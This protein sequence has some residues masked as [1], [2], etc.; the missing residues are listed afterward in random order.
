MTSTA[1]P[2]TP[3]AQRRLRRSTTDRIA[4]GVAG[5]L[6]EYFGLDPI[7]FRI[8][9]A[10]SAFF[11]GAGVI[12]Y[13]VAWAAIPSS[14]AEAARLDEWMSQLR[15]HRRAPWIALLIGAVVLWAVGFSWWA[16]RPFLPL[17]AI[18]VIGI[19]LLSRVERRGGSGP[20]PA[21]APHVPSPPPTAS[22]GTE[23]MPFA[24]TAV[25]AQPI[26][27]DAAAEAGVARQNRRRQVG[28]VRSITLAV[29]IATLTVLAICDA[30]AGIRLPV[31][32]WVTGGIVLIGMLVGAV[33]RRTPWSLTPLLIFA[34]IG[35][36]AFGNTGASLHD[37][38]GQ[39]VWVPTAESQLSDPPRLAFGQIVVDLR[40]VTLTQPHDIPVTLGAGQ[41]RV[42]LPAQMNAAVHA[43]VHAG[44][45]T[46]DGQDASYDWWT[47]HRGL[48]IDQTIVP[49]NG[50]TGPEVDIYVHLAD[51]HLSVE[52]S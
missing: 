4:G 46:V 8:L 38:V 21:P 15:N 22:A 7:L 26:E 35:I 29:L 28:Y 3:Q 13:L 12:A 17:L 36:I 20:R 50:A 10:V 39:T 49:P 18:V 42:V 27:D 23:I 34:L 30:I 2:N 43:H 41:V 32:F 52:R 40:H 9:F 25:L 16:P 1:P 19:L 14:D 51:G 24:G 44:H 37:G 33:L 47:T 45:V 11:G 48:G 31:Y 5:G 6:G